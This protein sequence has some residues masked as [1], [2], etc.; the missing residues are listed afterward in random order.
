MHAAALAAWIILQ[1]INP[2]C[3]N[4]CCMMTCCIA[5]IRK[6]TNTPD[7]LLLLKEPWVHWF[8]SPLWPNSPDKFKTW[9]IAHPR[10]YSG[11]PP[12][13]CPLQSNLMSR[14]PGGGVPY[15]PSRSL[16]PSCA[17]P[18]KENFRGP[19]AENIARTKDQSPQHSSTTVKIGWPSFPQSLGVTEEESGIL[20]SKSSASTAAA[21]CRQSAQAF[22]EKKYYAPPPKQ[23]RTPLIYSG[24][25]PY[26][27]GHQPVRHFSED[28]PSKENPTAAWKGWCGSIMVCILLAHGL[29]FLLWSSSIIYLPKTYPRSGIWYFSDSLHYGRRVL[30]ASSC[31]LSS[32]GWHWWLSAV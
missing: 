2:S 31:P 15:F 23:S 22:S 26:R 9:I 13:N 25:H 3:I 11:F 18:W 21:F 32:T 28:L 7:G 12:S 20:P 6:C 24:S 16:K 8:V 4:K 29:W 19:F 1:R 17:S 27:T 30:R 14:F 10:H 5:E